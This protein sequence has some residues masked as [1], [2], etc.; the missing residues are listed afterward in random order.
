MVRR[1]AFTLIELIFAIVVI[2][3][4]VVSLPVMTQRTDANI[5]AG[6]I[7]EAIFASQSVV[8]ESMGY[9]WDTNTLY[10]SLTS[11]AS[12]VI[13]TNGISCTNVAVG[14]RQRLGHITRQCVSDSS[15]PVRNN[16]GIIA[17]QAVENLATNYND[18]SI[19]RG[20]S[21]TT[22][23]A[24][25]KENYKAKATIKHCIDGGGCIAFGQNGYDDDLKEVSFDIKKNDGEVV[26]KLRYYIANIGEPTIS[27][28]TF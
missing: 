6:I 25:Y 9:Y 24:T 20:L 16:T 27:K 13:D 17:A 21:A 1:S 26:V 14:I 5:E 22:A 4:A 19:L 10:D 12:R 2:A 3:I 28:R 8:N 11:D 7:Q 18:R 15:V 23:Y